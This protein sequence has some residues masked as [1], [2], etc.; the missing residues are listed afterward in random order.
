MHLL[1]YDYT[2]VKYEQR[3]YIKFK[4]I[5]EDEFLVLLKE[6]GNTKTC[7]ISLTSELRKPS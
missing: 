5:Y 6:K 2:Y 4:I 1:V 3:R 7:I